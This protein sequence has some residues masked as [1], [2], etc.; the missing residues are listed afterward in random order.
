MGVADLPRP[1]G[2]VL[3]GGGSLGAV[4]V[5]MLQALGEHDIVPG[6]VAGTSVGSLNGA[7]VA[8]DPKG[9]ANRLSHLWVR[10][11][12]G[13]V[14][15]GGLL[16]QARTLQRT[17][18]HLF[19]NTGLAAVITQFLGT[20]ITFADL[21]LPFAAVAMDIATAR[22]HVLREGPLLPALLAS[23]AIPGIFPP[24]QFGSLQLYDGGLVSNVPMRRHWPWVLDRSS[25][26]TAASTGACLTFPAQSPRCSF[27]P[28]WCHALASRPGRTARGRRRA[29]HLLAW[30]RA[31]PG[32]P[33]GFPPHRQKCCPVAEALGLARGQPSFGEGREVD[34]V[35]RGDDEVGAGRG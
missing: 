8:L 22:P 2:Y 6:V 14:F 24:V 21:P 25:S 17:K 18:T 23:T 10:L 12:R 16:A 13:D 26:W 5:G 20:A 30:P 15:P 9:A 27:I 33:A 1:V 7:V 3:G 28:R 29:G 4:Q 32:V 31:A 11:T 34:V 35:E 19:P